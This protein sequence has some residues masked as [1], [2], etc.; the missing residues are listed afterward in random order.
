MSVG[1]TIYGL[2]SSSQQPDMEQVSGGLERKAWSFLGL[3]RLPAG[4]QNPEIL[5]S[6]TFS[7]R[8]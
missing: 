5:L 1:R 8:P 7:L 4:I 3:G 2:I 6:G